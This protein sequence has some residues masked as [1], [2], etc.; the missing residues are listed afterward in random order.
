[1]KKQMWGLKTVY[2]DW[3]NGSMTWF[4]TYGTRREARSFAKEAKATNQKAYKAKSKFGYGW[5]LKVIK[6][7]VTVEEVL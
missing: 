1:M 4:Q 7:W 2:S 3:S 6:V 5:K